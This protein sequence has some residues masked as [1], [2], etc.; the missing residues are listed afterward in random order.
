MIL[1]SVKKCQVLV[2]AASFLMVA[3]AGASQST[4]SAISPTPIPLTPTPQPTFTH[5]PTSSPEPTLTPL[6][7]IELN[8]EL[9]EGDHEKG[10]LTAIRRGCHGCH[11]DEEHPERG[12]RFVA[13]DDLPN[14]FERGEFRI[15]DPAY[16]GKAST[17]WEYVIESILVP[18]AY[19]VPGGWNEPMPVPTYNIPTE[20]DLADII[21]WMKTLE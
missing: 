14:I 18:E 19:F 9:P 1:N 12:P 13:F 21:A 16:E 7:A 15:A 11:V 17:N 4:P 2:L 8:I 5:E 3:C 20:Q 6:P 10:Y